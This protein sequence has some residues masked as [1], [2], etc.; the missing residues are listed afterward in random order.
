MS[1]PRSTD[2]AEKESAPY[3]SALAGEALGTFNAL[4]VERQMCVDQALS[5]LEGDPD[6]EDVR[7]LRSAYAVKACGLWIIF[8]RDDVNKRL[9]IVALEP[10]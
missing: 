6:A 1:S 10:E 3:I 5:K 9:D 7:A 4:G 8:E 2:D